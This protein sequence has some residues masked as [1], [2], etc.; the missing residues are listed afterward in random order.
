[1]GDRRRLMKSA[2]T[3]MVGLG[4]VI[5]LVSLLPTPT[6]ARDNPK[7]GNND[8][9]RGC[10]AALLPPEELTGRVFSG[11]FEAL[12]R[13]DRVRLEV[14]VEFDAADTDGL[15]F[16]GDQLD[17]RVLRGS[18]TMLSEDSA[19]RVV[20]KRRGGKLVGTYKA[21]DKAVAQLDHTPSVGDFVQVGKNLN[22]PFLPASFERIVLLQG[23]LSGGER[24]PLPS[25]RI[26]A[27]GY[28]LGYPPEVEISRRLSGAETLDPDVT[29]ALILSSGD[30]MP[31]TFS[32]TT[33]NNPQSL[34][35]PAWFNENRLGAYYEDTVISDVTICGTIGARYVSPLAHREG[36]F[37][38]VNNIIQAIEWNTYD[39]ADI[40]SA[41][42]FNTIVANFTCI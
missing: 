18:E 4:V 41:S 9:R 38:G 33:A 35:V 2:A 7:G 15:V 42:Q 1:M 39:P 28:V 22:D 25:F 23:S 5:T 14:E 29:Y 10:S 17:V 11:H 8:D 32:I 21:K 27:A 26:D 19:I 31:G 36:V 40:Q 16:P 3:V 20:A 37:L 24:C 13:D 34:T 30:G 6:P 12:A